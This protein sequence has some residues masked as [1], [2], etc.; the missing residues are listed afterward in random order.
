MAKQWYIEVLGIGSGASEKDIRRAYRRLASKYHPD[1]NPSPFAKERMQEL[2]AALEAALKYVGGN[3]RSSKHSNA[4]KQSRSRSDRSKTGEDIHRSAHISLREAYFGCE[5]EISNGRRKVLVRIP[6]GAQSNDIIR[7]AREGE[8][9][10][11]GGR[12][13]DLLVTVQVEND[14]VFKRDGDNLIFEVELGNVIDFGGTINVPAFS[15]EVSMKIPAGT[16][17]GQ[18][19]RLS[20]K[21]MPNSTGGFG[22]MIV[23]DILSSADSE[24]EESKQS[25]STEDQPIRAESE[26]ASAIERGEAL[27]LSL[28]SDITL[29]SALPPVQ[30]NLRIVGNGFTISG[31]KLFRIFEVIEGASLYIEQLTLREG[32][33]YYGGAIRNAGELKISNCIF[34]ENTAKDAGGAIDNRNDAILRSTGC[35]FLNNSAKYNGGAINDSAKSM[36][37]ISCVFKNNSSASNGGAI[38]HTGDMYVDRCIFQNNSANRNGGAIDNSGSASIRATECDFFDNSAKSYGGAINDSCRS[39]SV[40]KCIFNRN[41]AKQGGAIYYW[42]KLLRNTALTITESEFRRNSSE[43]P[44]GAIHIMDRPKESTISINHYWNNEPDNCRGCE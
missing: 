1:K 33:A 7:S 15:G 35:K 9:G 18:I 27:A 10:L 43:K 26:L 25:S 20:G 21:G 44:G 22:D 39:T 2:N 34:V 41:S 40:D 30:S 11:N 16:K 4:A 13:G 23:V 32:H 29:S 14:I 12:P 17:D 42:G 19:F 3:S 37:I 36:D 8:V 5:K 6:K 31:D 24:E 28:K 38:R